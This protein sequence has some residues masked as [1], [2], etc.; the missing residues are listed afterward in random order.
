MLILKK[1]K[2]Y[3]KAESIIVV[4]GQ[5]INEDAYIVRVCPSTVKNENILLMI[6]TDAS[7]LFLCWRIMMN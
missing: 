6:K 3:V 2:P 4:S 1:C 7:T 5:S